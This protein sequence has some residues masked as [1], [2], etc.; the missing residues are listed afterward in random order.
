LPLIILEGESLPGL[1]R[2]SE[3]KN[4]NA[5]SPFRFYLL[6]LY[7]LRCNIFG[8]PGIMRG[9]HCIGSSSLCQGTQRS[10][11]AKH[12]SKRDKSPDLKV[13]LKDGSFH[14]VDSSELAFRLAA[15]IA[16]KD[17]VK[18][19]IPFLLEPIMSIEI[20]TPEEYVGEVLGNFNSK[21]GMIEWIKERKGIK[22]IRGLPLL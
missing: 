17:G 14:E 20:V 8:N 3:A 5:Q 6:S 12:L 2:V 16:F 11:I 19:A 21:R 18:K 7:Y 13:I 9:F 15:S 10:S 4:R 22:V 1:V